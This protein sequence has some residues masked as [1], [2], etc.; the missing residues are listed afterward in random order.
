MSTIINATTTNGVVIQ[1]DNSGSLQLATNSGTTAVTI[2]TSQNVGIGTTV[3]RASLSITNTIVN[4]AGTPNKI[5]LYDDAA[6]NLYGFNISSGA[7]EIIAGTSGNIVSYTNG[8]ERMRID[9]S[10]IVT[11][12]AGNLMLV[13]S[14]SQATTSGTSKDFT[15]I[16]SWV[17]KITVMFNGVS[18]SGS[19]LYQ[20]QLGTSGGIVSTGYTAYSG[21]TPSATG[22]TAT[23]G[24]IMAFAGASIPRYGSMTLY[25]FTGN[26]WVNSHAAGALSASV[27][28]G[29]CGGG[30]IALAAALTTVRLTTVNGTDTFN[31]GSVNIL[32][33]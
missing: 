25:N 32:Y 7:L 8:S 3:P 23:T 12:T 29:N 4:S 24:M 22:V 5:R 26:T 28:Y 11:G 13:Q 16:P 9:G 21:Q 30:S 19:S 15:S 17:K 14:T 33:E 10:G 18:S 27:G 1:P 6:S 2:D 31:A 20:I